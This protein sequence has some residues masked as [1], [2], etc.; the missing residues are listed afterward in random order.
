M[1]ACRPICR[2]GAGRMTRSARRVAGVVAAVC[3]L[4]ALP[5]LGAGKPATTKPIAPERQRE[6]SRLLATFFRS[7]R[8]E[9]WL[10]AGQRILEIGSTGPKRLL[11]ALTTKL[12]SFRRDYQNAFAQ[13]AVRVR[14]DKLSE[15]AKDH[16][17]SRERLASELRKARRTALAL[18]KASD[19][20]AERITREADPVMERL[21]DLLAVDRQTLLD[22]SEPLRRQ[23]KEL[24]ALTALRRRCGDIVASGAAGTKE[25][26]PTGAPPAPAE[27]A[28]DPDKALAR[29]EELA[30][31]LAMP[32]ERGARDTL[33]ANAKLESRLKPEEVE[34]IRDLNRIRLLLGLAPLRIDLKLCQAAR[35][36]C[37][38]MRTGGFFS[39]TSPVPGKRTPWDRARKAGTTV[40]A[41][42]IA[43]ASR[44]GAAA[45]RMW[46]HSPG[47]VRNMLGRFSRVGL[48]YDQKWTMM[49]GK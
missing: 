48:G 41:E 49:L 44:S 20:T 37:T 42:N 16:G 40:S 24:L 4:A 31:L 21:N 27:G 38:D 1:R 15:A 9:E 3:T 13:Q 23:R 33:L 25:G 30:A 26:D 14:L 35:D 7:S 22:R 10:Q 36:H 46:F 2:P 5:P 19:L 39:H 47:H 43:G 29:F 45:N 32:M 12:R 28:Y 17:G 6:L 11:P 34:G 8:P 18:L